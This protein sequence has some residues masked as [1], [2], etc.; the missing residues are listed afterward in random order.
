LDWVF[1]IGCPY[2]GRAFL[3]KSLQNT[4]VMIEEK[5]KNIEGAKQKNRVNIQY[6][7]PII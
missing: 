5:Q 3:N 7:S 2:D 6:Y 4:R 1:Y